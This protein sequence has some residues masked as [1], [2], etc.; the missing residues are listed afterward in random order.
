MKYRITKPYNMSAEVL[1]P[2]SKSISNRALVLEALSKGSVSL[3]TGVSDCDDTRVMLR[4]LNQLAQEASG[5]AP[6]EPLV[7][8]VM[9][10]G[11]SM[12]FLTALLAV[13]EGT[14]IIT[15]TERMCHRPIGILVEALRQLGA[16]ITY[17]SEEGFPPLRIQGGNLHGGVVQLSGDVSSQYVSALLMIGP[18]LAEGLTLQ[19]TGQVVSRPYIEMTL[20]IM[21]SFG[22]SACW[23]DERTIQ[24]EPKPYSPTPYIIESDWSAASYWYSM[25]FL[26]ENTGETATLRGLQEKSLQG[27]SAVRDIFR[28]LGVESLPLSTLGSEPKITLVRRGQ[29]AGR[30]EW[31]FTRIPDLAQTIVVACAMR[32]IAFRF[33]GLQSLKIKETD[34][35]AA[36]CAELEKLGVNLEVENDSVLSW[37]GPQAQRG[38]ATH[39]LKPAAGTAIDTYED[40]RMAMAFAP[41]SWVLGSIDI[42]NPQ[43]VSK[44][45]PAYWDD[46]RSAGFIIDEIDS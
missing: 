45:Y 28:T 4:A 5:C 20:A 17:E 33:T 16:E 43:V 29:S 27:D 12:R 42:N 36:L 41:A 38:G 44:S 15:G 2:A 46:L 31:D 3:L 13:T 30:L 19:L 35:I 9:A 22:G 10:A 7:I 23:L 40:H 8:N 1:L 39:Y 24:V 26:S 34:R 6:Q 18:L 21:R 25:V 37:D 11:T 14:H 32:G